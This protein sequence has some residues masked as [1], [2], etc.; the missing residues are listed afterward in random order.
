M[1]LN[2]LNKKKK[3]CGHNKSQN[4]TKTALKKALNKWR[5]K[6]K[7]TKKKETKRKKKK[8]FVSLQIDTRYEHGHGYGRAK[9]EATWLGF[10]TSWLALPMVFV[11][12]P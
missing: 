2:V 5:T 11:E 4:S 12:I 9:N 3:K 6:K 10:N 7:N 1:Q 8:K